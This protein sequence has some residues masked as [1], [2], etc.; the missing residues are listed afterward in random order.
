MTRAIK[1][2]LIANR[3][4]IAVRVMRTAKRLGIRTVAV[5]SAADAEAMH[6]FAADEAIH[7]GAASAS[8]SYLV[9]DKIIDACKR[10]GAD[11][12][13]PGY[14]FL[15]ENPDFARRLKEEDILFL[16]PSPEAMEAMALKGAAKALMVEAGVPVVPG[17]HGDAQDTA[18]L[19]AEADRIGYP[20]LIKA[21]A[22]GGGKG[23]RQVFQKNELEEAIQSAR[24][25]GENSF[26][27][28][29]LLIEKYIQK[30]RH[31]EFQIF[32]D[33]HGH[34]V[35]LMERDCSI[36][37][38]H[39]KVVEE[40][41]APGMPDALR[42]K[43]GDAA[44][45]AAQSIGY[46][47]AGTIE[48]IVDVANGLENAE[49]YFMEMN[50]RLQVE[51]PVTEEITDTDLV[52]W[53]IRV[54]EG[55]ALPM[56]QPEILARTRGHAIELRLYAED[57]PGGFLPSAGDI[58]L[59][60]DG[61]Q[62]LENVRLETG[63]YPQDTVSV[64][65]DPM[66]AKLITWGDDRA[67]ATRTM[68][69]VLAEVKARGIATNRDF[70]ARIMGHDAFVAADL[71]TGFI[72]RFK[73]DLIHNG[74]TDLRDYFLA[75][76]ALLTERRSRAELTAAAGDAFAA[77]DNFRLNL[78]RSEP[79]AF[80][81]EDGPIRVFAEDD[82]QGH[83]RLTMGTLSADLLIDDGDETSVQ[84]I[85][86]GLR[87]DLPVRIDGPTV[88]LYLADRT[89]TLTRDTGFSDTD[90]GADG[91]GT[92]TAPMPG[93]ILSVHVADG[94]AVEKGAPLLV[95]EAM[96]MEQSLKAPRAGIISDIA[97]AVGDLVGDGAVLLSIIDETSL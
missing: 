60:L 81:G 94:D 11:A 13:H 42:S 82:T 9:I 57:V 51:H 30:P 21:V 52:E 87:Y 45:K 59:D 61:V 68:Q 77:G 32:G 24:R 78:V 58:D 1:T 63:I 16:G 26:G 55:H 34:V 95:M 15:S 4:E 6:R 80:E 96:K 91:P 33:H 23:M 44:V 83:T 36:Q 8:E 38:R 19:T 28:G 25:E 22:G 71:D 93:K 50:T 56:D 90:G 85:L 3:G 74:T 53:Q 79:F 7:I 65:Y 35:H 48:F 70:L 97:C 20:V 66:I 37:R 69:A 86:D 12:V 10:T 46:A 73:T 72:D 2:L 39:Q 43:M 89:T 62:G 64:H 75:T 54:A 67:S 18:T 40:A 17:Y 31:I 88:T 14:G 5:Y 92:V 29:K 76:A 47:G 27:N 49:F 84:F 41:P